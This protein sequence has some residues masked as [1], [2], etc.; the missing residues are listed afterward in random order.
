MGWFLI[1]WF[2]LLV[3]ILFVATSL[4]MLAGIVLC[5]NAAIAVFVVVRYKQLIT[6]L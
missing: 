1:L 3:S 5:S 2:I 4:D 6:A